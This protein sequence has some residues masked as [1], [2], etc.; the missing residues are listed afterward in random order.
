[1]ISSYLCR[2]FLLG[3]Y[4]LI[5][6]TKISLF[7]FFKLSLLRFLGLNVPS[8]NVFIDAGFRFIK[9]SNITISAFTSFGHDNHFWAFNPIIIGPYVQTAKDLLIIS[10]THDLT[11]FEAINDG[12]PVVIEAG[13]WIGAR[14]TIL[15][16]VTIGKGSVIGA[17]SLVNKDIP[18]FSIAAGNPCKVIRHREPSGLTVSPFGDYDIFT[19]R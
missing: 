8:N 7:N 17:G 14:V 6:C 3:L 2:I 15:H 12:Q 10:G 18:P 19:L 4:R 13:C 9:P 5:P 1:M 16:G 11:T